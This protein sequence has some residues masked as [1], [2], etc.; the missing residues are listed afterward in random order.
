MKVGQLI[1]VLQELDPEE[2][3]LYVQNT[4]I[5]APIKSV[6]ECYYKGFKPESFVGLSCG[7]EIQRDDI[8]ASPVYISQKKHFL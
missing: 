4:G 5:M 2:D 8:S 1:K 3:V 6:Q 7:K